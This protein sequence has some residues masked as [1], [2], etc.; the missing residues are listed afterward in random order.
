MADTNR[1]SLYLLEESTFGTTPASS[2]WATLRPTGESLQFGITNVTSDEIRSDRNITDLVQTDATVTGDLNFEL[3][4]GSFDTLLEGCMCSAFSANVLKNGTTL[5]SYSIEK[6]FADVSRYH[7]YKGCRVGGM[8]LSVAS[9][10]IVTGSFSF[11]G[12]NAIAGNSSA[13]SGTPSAQTT[14]TPFN[15]VGNLG[16]LKEG[17][18]TLS[19]NVMSINLTI[20]NNLRSNTAIGT[21]GSTGIG[22]GTF[23]VSGSM[24]VYFANDTLYN[25]YLAST[26]SSLE[27]TLTDASSNAYTFLLP[28]IKYSSGTV[29]AGSQNADLMAELGFQAIYNASDTAT[30]KITRT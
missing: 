7:T 12:K 23:E 30:I 2:A 5:K 29:M 14:T 6:K 10:S 21:L 13:S 11:Q 4:H 22:L 20:S 16:T 18:S 28:K 8:N 15:A 24:S 1:T 17:G 3:S 26:A 9:G 25:K 19:D 27:F